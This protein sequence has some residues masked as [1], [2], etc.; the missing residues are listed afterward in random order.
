MYPSHLR[1]PWFANPAVRRRPGARFPARTGRQAGNA[2]GD[3]GCLRPLGNGAPALNAVAR[4]GTIHDFYGFPEPLYELR[5]NA[6]G[7]P[8]L[9]E[10][11]SSLLA[12]VGLQAHVDTERGL[13]HGAWVPLMLMY[14]KA[15]IPVL[16]LSVQSHAGAAITSRWGARSRRCARKAC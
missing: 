2:K 6:P 16:Q 10:R 8:A 3:S 5:Y 15:D 13:D 9:A 7:A 14:P 12:A 11:V 1:I 4:N